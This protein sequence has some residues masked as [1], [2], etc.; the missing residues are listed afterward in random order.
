L[1]PALNSIFLPK[2]WALTFTGFFSV[3]FDI[4]GKF[5]GQAD[6]IV[7]EYHPCFLL[8]ACFIPSVL[9]SFGVKPILAYLGLYVIS[10]TTDHFASVFGNQERID[11]RQVGPVDF[12]TISQF[13]LQKLNQGS[14]H[15]TGSH[16]FLARKRSQLAKWRSTKKQVLAT[17][18]IVLRPPVHS[19]G[20]YLN[21]IAEPV[22]KVDEAM[23]VSLHKAVRQHVGELIRP[24]QVERPGV[25]TVTGLLPSAPEEAPSDELPTNLLS[26]RRSDEPAVGLEAEMKQP[27]LVQQEQEEIVVAFKRRGR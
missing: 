13:G 23:K 16:W 11:H 15:G 3:C 2:I 9:T 26:E 7:V 20:H 12:Q 19:Q 6:K 1:P 4:L 25:L 21:N 14:D 8:F 22:A 18:L 24:E 27:D 17:R 5:A 10:A